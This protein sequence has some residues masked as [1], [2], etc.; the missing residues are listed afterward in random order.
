MSPMPTSATGATKVMR[1]LAAAAVVLAACMAAAAAAA[2]GAAGDGAAP[3]AGRSTAAA[4]QA[5]PAPGSSAGA[6]RPEAAGRYGPLPGP[7]AVEAMDLD[8]FDQDRNRAVPVRVYFPRRG[9]GPFPVVVFSSALGAG[10][11]SLEFLGRHLASHGY[12]SVHI[13]HLGADDQIPV[14]GGHPRAAAKAAR[15]PRTGIAR[16]LDLVFVLDQVTGLA[17]RSPVLHGRIDLAAVAAGGHYLGAWTALA[18]AGLAAVGEDGEESSLPDPRVKAALLIA[19][20]PA[21]PQ[22]RANLRFEH[23]KV[24]CLYLLAAPTAAQLQQQQ[25]QQQRQQQQPGPGGAAAPARLA[26]DRISGADQVLVTFLGEPG[27]PLGPRPAAAGGGGGG[28]GAGGGERA[29]GGRSG[30]GA[31]DASG[32]RAGSGGSAGGGGQLE[33]AERIKTVSTAF[34]EAYLRHDAAAREWLFGGGLAAALGKGASVE[35]R[36]R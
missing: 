21:P 1:R 17:A 23:I 32:A 18:A 10:R 27:P 13:Q 9:A 6:A 15:D 2:A 8:W 25:P 4:A 3:A 28:D 5:P 7:F 36:P 35:T 16:L 12:V 34:L 29:G 20:P 22:Q 33:L 24:P 14:S 11:A 30:G 26:F 31:G 19:L